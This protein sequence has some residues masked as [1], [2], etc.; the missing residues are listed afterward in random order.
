MNSLKL[1][2]VVNN[3]TFFLSHRLPI[4][5]AALREGYDVT[6][7]TKD[8]GYK[9]KIES[10]GLKFKN[11]NFNRSKRD[12]IFKVGNIYKLY[13]IY[14]KERPDIIHHVTLYCSIIGCCA[15]KLA[16]TSSAVNAISGGGYNF[17]NG[18]NGLKQKVLRFVM[19]MVFRNK[20]YHYILQNNDD[21]A[22]FKQSNHSPLENYHLIKGSGVSLMD[23]S[24]QEPTT[25]EKLRVLLPAR[26]LWDKGIREFIAAA[27]ILKDKF[28]NSV[29]FIILGHFDK[30]NGANVSKKE[31]FS[32][33]DNQY[34]KWID[35][36]PKIIYHL[37]NADIVV[38]PSYREGLPKSLIDACAIGRPIITTNTHGCKECVLDGYNGYIVPV[39]DSKALA[40]KIELLLNDEQKRREMGKNSRL[41]A[42][43][44]F[45]IESVIEKH[46]E[47]YNVLTSSPSIIVKE[48]KKILTADR[49]IADKPLRILSFDIEQWFDILDRDKAVED[50]GDKR[51]YEGV[52]LLLQFLEKHSYKATFFVVGDI[53]KQYPDLVRQIAEKYE[54]GT[55]SMHHKLV[56]EMERDEF[57]TDLF[58]SIH[59]IEDV[60]GK[61]VKYYR[62]P[63]F[64]LHNEQ[65]WTFDIMSEAGIEID[66][67]LTNAVTASYGHF[68]GIVKEPFILNHNGIEMKELPFVSQFPVLF[69]A[70][71][72][73]RLLNYR[74]IKRMT[75]HSDYLMSYFHP[76]DFDFRQP[77][78]SDVSLM[79]KFKSYYGLRNTAGK[80]DK[81]LSD[82]EFTDIGT[83]I[84]RIDWA[85]VPKIDV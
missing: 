54:I 56:Y 83:A 58:E 10:Y 14:R 24:Y 46:L 3:D 26:I 67:S 37:T 19:N 31:L 8:N 28:L 7:V 50:N 61:K 75:K 68:H 15:A 69:S 52:D 48:N 55:H 65:S 9:D 44:N 57:R 5:L 76:R 84:Q 32:L 80:F 2:I 59:T 6:I 27:T 33:I 43:A 82:F 21:L 53:A 77:M 4:A 1:F 40:Q 47:I 29:E 63:G 79:R 64:S 30:Q 18:R 13:K 74:A 35:F 78:L 45:N 11:L 66:S 20:N 51:I 22:E 39:K 72:Y 23:F 62:A 34:I 85:K 81:W 12:V 73:F 38:L 42:E 70:G 49:V 60:I 71:G 25:K 17:T 36:S 16:G 41:F